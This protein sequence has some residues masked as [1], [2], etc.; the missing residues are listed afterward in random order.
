MVLGRLLGSFLFFFFSF[1]F[2]FHTQTIQ[3][4]LFEFKWVDVGVL[5]PRL[6]RQLL[7]FYRHAH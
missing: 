7:V 5:P 2:L 6:A 1:L 3:T 4:I